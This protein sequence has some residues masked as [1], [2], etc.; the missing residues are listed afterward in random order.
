MVPVIDSVAAYAIT[1]FM[2]I[3]FAL[4]LF[5]A[6]VQPIWC[7]IDCA[8]DR[9]RS[10]GGKAVWI[11]VLILLYGI[12]NW[13]YGA[14]AAGGRWLRRVTWLAWICAILL[15]IAF[16]AMYSMHEDF[17]RGIDQEWRHGRDLVVVVD[18]AGFDT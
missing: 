9:R 10:G 4:M 1:A 7:L 14:F 16:A 5:M 6:L 18:R 11:V 15:T 12:A 3:A 13:F 8:V 17:R 2:V